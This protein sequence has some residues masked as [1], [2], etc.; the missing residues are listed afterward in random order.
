M[1]SLETT[2]MPILLFL[3]GYISAFGDHNLEITNGF[4]GLGRSGLRCEAGLGTPSL[5]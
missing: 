4:Q 2:T 5:P 1:R 3:E